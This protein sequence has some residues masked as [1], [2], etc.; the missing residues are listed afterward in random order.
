MSVF[1]N[2]CFGSIG[3]RCLPAADTRSALGAVHAF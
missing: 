1:L 2:A 3:A